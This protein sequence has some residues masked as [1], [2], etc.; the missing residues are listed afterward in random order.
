MI[1]AEQPM[2]RGM[3]TLTLVAALAIGAAQAEEQSTMPPQQTVQSAPCKPRGGS[4]AIA[5]L[6][7]VPR[8]EIDALPRCSPQ[9]LPSEQIPMWMKTQKLERELGELLKQ[10]QMAHPR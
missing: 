4:I 6:A 1:E 10:E 2:S 8:E 9:P 5:S 3:I 7:P